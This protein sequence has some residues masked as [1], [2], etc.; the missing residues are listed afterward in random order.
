MI[1]IPA[2]TRIP[3]MLASPISAKAHAGDAVRAT[4]GFPVTVGTQLAIPVGSYVEGAI[5][6]VIKSGLSGPSVKMHFTRLLYSNG[7]SVAMQGANTQAQLAIPN[8]PAGERAA[9]GSENGALYA[10][11]G[12]STGQLPAVQPLPSH[13]GLVVGLGVAGAAAVI[14]VALLG[15]YHRAGSSVLFD[16]GWQFEMVLESPLLVDAAS[17]AATPA[18]SAP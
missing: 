11:G 12:Q 17:V 15:H 9:S 5:D 7:Y 16:T 6:K 14:A 13:M 18:S 1:T 10:V 2:G 4:T 8:S 3:L